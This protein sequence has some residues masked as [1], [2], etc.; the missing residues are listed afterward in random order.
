MSVPVAYQSSKAAIAQLCKALA[1]E[2][3][4]FGIR[5]TGIAPGWTMTEMT[6]AVAEDP[7]K[8]P[9][10]LKQIPLGRWATPSDYKGISILLAS[11]AGDYIN[12]VL[13]PVDGGFLAR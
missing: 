8:Y 9:S 6:A 10:T 5:T 1:D 12:G 2:W 7:V 11:H 4:E 13:I 3:S